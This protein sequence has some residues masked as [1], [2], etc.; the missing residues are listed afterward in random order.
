[1]Y[2]SAERC[3]INP[4]EG[5]VLE[6]LLEVSLEPGTSLRSRS[7]SISVAAVGVVASSARVAGTVTL[8]TRLDPNN[9]INKRITGV[10]GR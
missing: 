2:S 3:C 9:G 5:S 10:G 7:K 1:M 8:S 6:K 4:L